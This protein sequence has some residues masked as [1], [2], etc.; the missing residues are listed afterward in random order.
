MMENILYFIK[1]NIKDIILFALIFICFLIIIFKNN[2]V[3]ALDLETSNIA[4]SDF[5]QEEKRD[6]DTKAIFHVD[7]KGAV[8]NPGVYQVEEGSIIND[9]I[10]LAGG[11]NS[12]AYQ[13]SINLSKKVSDE[14]V[15]YVY[16]KSEIKEYEKTNNT[17]CVP[18][19]NNTY[20]NDTKNE[21]NI[22]TFDNDVTNEEESLKKI[23]LAAGYSICNC[24]DEKIS[25]IE[26]TEENSTNSNLVNIN[27][28]TS[29][30]LMTISGI[31]SSKAQAIIKYR[32]ETGNFKTV[33]DIMN[34]SGI[35]E[36]LFAK[37]KDYITV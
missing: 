34:V 27:R 24:V 3:E 37:I 16:T 15:I 6:N 2:E 9:I 25:V 32:E 35:G 5:S 12:N 30:E 26:N 1:K 10:T 31:G 8:K 22:T 20:E 14:M 19:T 11:F 23:C 13:N 18:S 17:S 4:M 33:E 36:S 7:I 29:E 28:A 21:T